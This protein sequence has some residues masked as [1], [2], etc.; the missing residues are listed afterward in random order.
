MFGFIKEIQNRYLYVFS[1]FLLKFLIFFGSLKQNDRGQKKIHLYFF[2][3][4]DIELKTLPIR[5]K[6]SY[7]FN[8]SY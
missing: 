3:F 1:V 6:I 8:T 7:F 5:K 4:R 2:S